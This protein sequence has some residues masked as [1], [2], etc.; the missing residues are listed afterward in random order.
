MTY[1]P[2]PSGEQPAYWAPQPPKKRSKVWIWIVA[3]V[4]ALA[5]CGVGGIFLLGAAG[6]SVVHTVDEQANSRKLDVT[7]TNCKLGEFG[8]AEVSYRVFNHSK[9]KQDYLITFDLTG[10]GG[11]VFGEASD[12]VNGLQPGKTYTGK[13]VG[14][15]TDGAKTCSLKDA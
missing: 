5:L 13:A 8:M 7:I 3:G 15:Y 6:Q 14:P 10:D 4:V 12:I 9:E 2:G 1:Q 11:N